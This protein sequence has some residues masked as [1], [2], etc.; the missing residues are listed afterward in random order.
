MKF[1]KFADL[2]GHS[3]HHHDFKALLKELGIH[4][5]PEARLKGY[6]LNTT[7]RDMDIPNVYN[8]ELG[9]E[10]RF[11]VRRG[12]DEEDLKSIFTDNEYELI[13]KQVSFSKIFSNTIY[14]FGLFS[15]DDD[16]TVSQKID[17]KPARKSKQNP[18]GYVYT[19]YK[20]N[21]EILVYFSINK[22]IETL[23][24]SIQ[25]AIVKKNVKLHSS[26]KGQAKN[27]SSE[28]L[29]ELMSLKYS[30][31]TIA[32]LER[33]TT[34]SDHGEVPVFSLKT[35]G[36]ANQ[37]LTEFLTS[38]ENAV[39]NNKA[40]QI[41]QAIKKTVK[42]FNKLNTK[43]SQFIETLEREELVEYI[44]KAVGFTGFKIEKGADI[45]EEW[46]EW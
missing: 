17:E 19:Y 4:D 36:S 22:R 26:L 33:N 11:M 7:L 13:I 40:S 42:A 23:F 29:N 15:G 45:T 35:I 20:D 30:M 3:V 8:K 12:W 16:K 6:I 38:L 39:K 44:T 32:W 9:V 2:I 14:P 41:Q 34:S 37:I 21:L 18:K 43:D 10:F 28:H 25:D 24:M 5:T 1:E 27:I 31:P 46:R